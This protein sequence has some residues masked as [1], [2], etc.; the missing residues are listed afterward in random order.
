MALVEQKCGNGTCLPLCTDIGLG[1]GMGTPGVNDA[2]CVVCVGARCELYDAA[3]VVTA[4][5]V[6]A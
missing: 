1:Q 4:R 6:L 3:V 2:G 5:F